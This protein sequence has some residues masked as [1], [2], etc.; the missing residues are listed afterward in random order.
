MITKLESLITSL[1]FNE[2]KALVDRL[3][4]NEFEQCILELCFKS[5]SILF[6]SFIFD[7]IKEKE[8]ALL[9]YI[10]SIVLSQPLCHI[11][12]AYQAAFFHAKRAV[13]LEDDDVELKEYLLFFND[14]P[15]KL[16]NDQESKI[17][18]E[19]VIKIKPES[20]VANKFI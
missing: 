10:A 11:E 15:D 19:K 12:G 6:Y 18:A 17:L 3:S 5:E 9:H 1:K 14:I 13:E 4:I 16:L 2:A 7:M 20:Q 8:S